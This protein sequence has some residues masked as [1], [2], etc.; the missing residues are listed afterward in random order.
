MLAALQEAQHMLAQPCHTCTEHNTPSL[1]DLHKS[2]SLTLLCP[3][4]LTDTADVPML[5]SVL[6]KAAFSRAPDRQGSSSTVLTSFLV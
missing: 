6:T 4:Q 2:C 1:S 5:Q 3:A